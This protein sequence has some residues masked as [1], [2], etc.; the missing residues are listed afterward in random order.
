MIEITEKEFQ[1]YQLLKASIH[2]EKMQKIWNSVNSI[3]N[4]EDDVDKPIKNC[5]ALLA[6]LECQPVFSCC[7]YDYQGQP[8]HKSHQYNEPYIKLSRNVFSIKLIE[9]FD[10]NSPWK[11][12]T[13]SSI[14]IGM[15]DLE[16][17]RKKTKWS[18]DIKSIHFSEGIA[19]CIPW[20]ENFLSNYAK[21]RYKIIPDQVVLTDGNHQWKKWFK[22]HEYPP[23]ES[24]VIKKEDYL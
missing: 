1:E 16:L 12:T 7:G 9:N 20:L 18:N 19:D 3:K 8:I 5:V 6:L 14:S 23:K 21:E 15:I 24:W 13:H 17:I 22:Y 2:N 10:Y 4:L 11:F